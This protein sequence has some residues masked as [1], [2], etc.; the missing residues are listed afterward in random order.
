MTD[1]QR[2]DGKMNFEKSY[3]IGTDLMVYYDDDDDDD[4]DDVQLTNIALAL[5]NIQL[6]NTFAGINTFVTWGPTVD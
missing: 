5:T 1:A 2:E 4:D 6:P 3:M